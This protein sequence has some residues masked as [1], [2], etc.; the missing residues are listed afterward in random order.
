MIGFSA[1]RLDSVFGVVSFIGGAALMVA[2]I[3]IITRQDKQQEDS[4]ERNDEA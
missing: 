3:N 2:S 4:D 1:N